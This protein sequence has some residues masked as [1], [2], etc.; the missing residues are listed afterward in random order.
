MKPIIQSQVAECGL[1]CIA[2][3]ASAHGQTLSLADLRQRFP[4]SLKGANL[5]QLISYSSTL[6][7]SARPLRLDLDELG[8][9]ALPCILHWDLNHFV[10]LHKVGRKQVVVLDPAVGDRRLSLAEVS[11]H[12]TGVALELTPQA[13]FV[14]QV[15]APRLRLSQLTG[16]LQ[17]IAIAVVLE[18][19]AIVAPLFNQMVVD[20][21]LTSG[22][23]ELLTVLVWGFA[24]VLVI[25]TA[26]SLARSWLVMVLGQTL[27]L[28]WLGNVFAHL[29][30]LP[31]NW[32]EQ[33]H[34][35]DIS[36]RFGAVHDI[37][38]T[39]TNVMIEA[40]LDGVMT[41]AALVMMF[42]YSPTLSGVVVAA[43]VLYG[44]VRWASFV[45]FRNAAAERLVLA[46][47]EHS[48]F[49]ETLRAMTPLKLF[50]RE[51]ER[52]AR[53]QSLIVEVMNRD[54]RT[55]K[56]NI[57]FTVVNTFIFGV[58]NL[59]V[60][61]LGAKAIL[62]SQGPGSGTAVFTVGMLMA[63]TSYKGQF[64]GRISALINHG[65]S[66][67][68]LGLHSERLA[69]IALTPPEQDTPQGDLPEHDLAHLQPCLEL[70]NVSFRYG[71]GEPWILKNANLRIE[72]GENVAI[73]GPS[74][75]GKT[76]LLKVMLGLLQPVEGEVLY[77]GVPVRQLGMAN[78]RRKVGTVMQEDV[79]LT[80]SIADNIAFFDMA[81]DLQRIEA[82]GQLAQL[83]HDIVRM[84]MGY[85]TL[86]GE[87]GSGLSGG[88]KQRLLLARALYKQ[89]SV[90]ALDEATSHLDIGNEQAVNAVL[91]QMPLTRIVIAHRPETI[92][93]AQ[94]M[95][96]MQ[97]QT[98][99]DSL[100]Q[101]SQ[102]PS[103]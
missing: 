89:P 12:F 47:Q 3:V 51:Q 91:A 69:D 60:F 59:L 8:Q 45:P 79:L 99:I 78:V 38:R 10:V 16:K 22:D 72:A 82:C 96:R 28:Q 57:G 9:L 93:S 98:V 31:V 90:L 37:Q 20:D 55:A 74:G 97:G 65:I 27:S 43:A 64:T 18:L 49:I 88:Q 7:F 103:H 73:T 84:P 56:M 39:L 63:F 29:V 4:Q 48:H 86:V 40:L 42:L 33:R 53:W 61:W 32:F 80:G 58:E 36:S 11:R 35:G 14:T 19:F 66:L 5:K 62:A 26:L 102:K 52:R 1:A 23:Q 54:I 30:R 71:E 15:Q 70:R 67:K 50:G 94:R 24:L 68:M 34:L 100:E 41:L 2:M 77:G 83:H 46:G 87:L 6:G 75:C 85:Q 101:A 95:L 25:Q 13:S 76:T 81:P 92:A 17:I 21:V 44:L